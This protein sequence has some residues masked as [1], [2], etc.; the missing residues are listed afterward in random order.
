MEWL[1]DISEI[2]KRSPLFAGQRIHIRII[3]NPAAGGFTIRRRVREH[4]ISFQNA[5]YRV[6][7]IDPVAYI[8]D[9]LVYK[10]EHKGHGAEI[11]LRI[12]HEIEQAPDERW[13][14]V[15][16]GGDGTSHEIQSACAEAVFNARVSSV[17]KELCILRLPLGTGND[18]SDGRFLHESIALLSASKTTC[19]IRAVSVTH[20]GFDAPRY[21]FNITSVGFDAFVTH[22]TNK[23]KRFFPGDIYKVWVDLSCLFYNGLYPVEPMTVSVF[24]NGHAVARYREETLFAL[25]GA[26]G[27]RTY[28]AGIK[29]LPDAANI[30]TVQDM[31][32]QRKLGL[33][34]LFKAGR[35]RGLDVVHLFE[36]NK[37]EIQYGRKILLQLDGESHLLEPD[38]FP[39][40][41]E[42]TEPLFK[43]LYQTP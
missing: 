38:H 32:L 35:H 27:N 5:V 31:S 36:G 43:G 14:L 33:K 13:L 16:A 40:T 37:L 12:L 20:G 15:I 25:M 1:S 11:A 21:A 17:V 3:A 8:V 9:C 30:C 41:M 7:G 24:N 19:P 29:I 34:P 28:G 6:S 23:V 39:L 22:M 10:T 4:R 26:S 2:A 18:G 42:L